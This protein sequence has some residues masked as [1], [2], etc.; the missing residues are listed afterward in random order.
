[1]SHF[2]QSQRFRRV[3]G[4]R[5][6]S[7]YSEFCYD[8]WGS[9]SGVGR[10]F[11]PLW[12]FS[13]PVGSRCFR[14]PRHRRH[15]RTLRDRSVAQKEDRQVCPTTEW[16]PRQDAEGESERRSYREKY[17]RPQKSRFPSTGGPRE[18]VLGTLYETHGVRGAKGRGFRGSGKVPDRVRRTYLERTSHLV[19]RS[20]GLSTRIL[21]TTVPTNLGPDWSPA[22]RP[23]RGDVRSYLG[24]PPVLKSYPY[25]S[26]IV[27]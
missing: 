12:S 11:V 25:F 14:N 4:V 10:D 18:R 3:F 7:L 24:P 1:M 2:P 13:S 8:S 26:E 6:P 20:S 9:D 17:L 5:G 22:P 23:G 27:V 16:S 19:S 15:D 21:S